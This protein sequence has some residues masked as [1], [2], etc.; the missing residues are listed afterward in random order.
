MRSA[1]LHKPKEAAMKRSFAL[2]MLL[3]VVAFAFGCMFDSDDKDNV[4]KGS[5]S[6]KVTMI[7]TGEPVKSVK[8][9][10]VNTDAKIDSSDYSKNRAAIVDSA[11]TDASGRYVIDGIAPG[12]Y[13]VSAMLSDS[14]AI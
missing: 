3:F 10:L 6:G 7:V 4:K 11:F 1:T 5:L 8:V 9:L 14:T 13:G 2:V 12:N